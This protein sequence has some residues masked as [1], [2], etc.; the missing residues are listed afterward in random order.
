MACDPQELISGAR[1]FECFGGNGVLLDAME[2]VMLCAI[3]DGDT[4]MACDP[5]TLVSQSDCII[6][7]VP[8]GMM[9]AVKIYLLCQIASGGGG[10]GGGGIL[11]GSG[12]P[13][14]A[15]ATACAVYVDT[16]DGTKYYYYL[17]AWH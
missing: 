12:A 4:S 6:Q 9:Q 14:A 5:Q 2:I 15:P 1:C 8:L 7:C 10:G 3:R 11:C 13:V 16:D 17:G